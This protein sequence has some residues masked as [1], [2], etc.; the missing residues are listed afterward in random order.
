L[1]KD[2]KDNNGFININNLVDDLESE[3]SG[4]FLKGTIIVDIAI[5]T[6]RER[7]RL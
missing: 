6:K 1:V 3:H 4:E 2:I 7:T 5:G